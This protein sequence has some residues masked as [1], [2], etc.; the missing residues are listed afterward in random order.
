MPLFIKEGAIIPKY[1]IQQYVDELE[2]KELVLEVYYKHGMEN[3]EL[4]EDAHDGYDYKK[5]RYSLRSFKLIG[6]IQEISI[7]Q[8]KDGKYS[9]SYE[10][11]KLRFHGLPFVIQ[12]IMVDNEEVNLE[13]LQFSSEEN[14]IIINKDFNN[15]QLMG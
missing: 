11:M 15:V 5:G 13:F 1:P 8:H 9:A 6:K 12:K 14:S 4:Y 7:Q 2:I 10:T 3:S